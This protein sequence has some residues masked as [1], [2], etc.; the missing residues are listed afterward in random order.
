MLAIGGLS[1]IIVMSGPFL[2]II[3]VKIASYGLTTGAV[4]TALSQLAKIKENE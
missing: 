4:G 2:P 1:S 3:I